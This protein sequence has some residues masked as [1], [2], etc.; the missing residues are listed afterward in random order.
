M[1]YNNSL[2][3]LYLTTELDYLRVLASVLIVRKY[4][5]Q[6]SSSAHRNC[7]HK[8]CAESTTSLLLGWWWNERRFWSVNSVAAAMHCIVHCKPLDTASALVFIHS[9]YNMTPIIISLNIFKNLTSLL[10]KQ[11]GNDFFYLD[12]PTVINISNN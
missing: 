6:K 12:G 3:I 5:N 4:S 9:I 11:F 7:A 10:Y 8:N 1:I 2:F